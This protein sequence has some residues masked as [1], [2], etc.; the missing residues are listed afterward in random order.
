LKCKKFSTD[1]IK[2]RQKHSNKTPGY[3][4]SNHLQLIIQMTCYELR[5][6][7]K[8]HIDCGVCAFLSP[9]TNSLT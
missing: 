9:S 3:G 8:I 2:P 5:G 1:K 7:T 6:Q 4:N